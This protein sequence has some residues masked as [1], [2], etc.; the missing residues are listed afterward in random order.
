M[1]DDE[2]AQQINEQR[3]LREA[4]RLQAD[5][6]PIATA[7][8]DSTGNEPSN[9]AAPALIVAGA[10]FLISAGLETLLSWELDAASR[11]SLCGPNHIGALIAFSSLVLLAAGI[12]AMT[13]ALRQ[14]RA[15]RLRRLAI[16]VGAAEIGLSVLLFGFNGL[17][18]F[19]AT[20][21]GGGLCRPVG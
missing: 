14:P 6:P 1:S 15:V 19:A 3:R 21:P 18:F 4:G 9:I 10:A 17:A 13:L 7:G 5:P 8:G 20:F 12:A 16:G 11:A 2:L